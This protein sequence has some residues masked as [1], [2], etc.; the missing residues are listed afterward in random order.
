MNTKKIITLFA[1]SPLSLEPA[2]NSRTFGNYIFEGNRKYN[3]VIRCPSGM[4]RKRKVAFTQHL[5]LFCEAPSC[6]QFG[7]LFTERWVPRYHFTADET[8]LF[9]LGGIPNCNTTS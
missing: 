5:P 4:E 2:G 6:A 8:K 7:E 9:S 1:L 3:L